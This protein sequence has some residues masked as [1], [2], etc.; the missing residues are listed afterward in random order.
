MENYFEI[1]KIA[2][3]H[4]IKGT[5]KIFPTT[6]DPT[7]FELLKEVILEVKGERRV[8]QIAKVAYHKILC[9]L[10]LRNLTI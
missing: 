10:R 1:G 7:R 6:D 2:G 9:C 3:T 8:C 4:G 5:L